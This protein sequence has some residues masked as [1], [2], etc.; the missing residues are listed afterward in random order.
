MLKLITQSYVAIISVLSIVSL[1][2]IYVSPPPSMFKSRDGV[3]HF[4]PKVMHPET[5]EPL[6]VGELIRHFRGD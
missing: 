4:T 6:E 2:Y 3:P 5:G 1:V